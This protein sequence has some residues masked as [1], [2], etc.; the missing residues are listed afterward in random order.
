[1][2]TTFIESSGFDIIDKY[3]CAEKKEILLQLLSHW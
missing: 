1:M 3:F 2:L